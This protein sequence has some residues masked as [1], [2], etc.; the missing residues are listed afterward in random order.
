MAMHRPTAITR[1]AVAWL[2]ALIPAWGQGFAPWAAATEIQGDVHGVVIENI[3]ARGIGGKVARL[4][5][6]DDPAPKRIRQRE[7]QGPGS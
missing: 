4:R 3:D 6:R 7:V 5:D 2:A 1:P